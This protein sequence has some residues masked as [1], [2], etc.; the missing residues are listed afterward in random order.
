MHVYSKNG[1][2]KTFLYLDA[3]IEF[4]SKE[5][6]PFAILASVLLFLFT[7][8][9]VLLMLFYPCRRFQSVLNR[10]NLNFQSLHT[11]MDVFMGYF[12]DGTDGTR[13]CRYFAAIHLVLRIL[14]MFGSILLSLPVMPIFI[15]LI[16]LLGI[17][18]LSLFRPYKLQ[19]NNIINIIV[20]G[21]LLQLCLILVGY[22]VSL[23]MDEALKIP[24]VYVYALS[25][26]L[27]AMIYL[28]LIIYIWRNFLT[29][30]LLN[31]REFVKKCCY[32]LVQCFMPNSMTCD[33]EVSCETQHLVQPYSSESDSN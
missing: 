32:L 5:H 16:L 30:Q 25:F 19:R 4:M 31:I 3:S 26:G 7:M 14:L 10:C 27:Q 13:D 11:F 12:K 9:P 24:L 28:S 18:L 20:M 33:S 23:C 29:K 8:F 2:H 21:F 15:C 1:E 6:L 17:M 22:Q